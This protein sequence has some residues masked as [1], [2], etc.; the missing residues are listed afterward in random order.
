M[1][2]IF[3]SVIY[4]HH[5]LQILIYLFIYQMRCSAFGLSKVCSC[6]TSLK[7][8]AVYESCLAIRAC[9]SW[10]DTDEYNNIGQ[11]LEPPDIRVNFWGLDVTLI[12]GFDYGSIVTVEEIYKIII[13]QRFNCERT[14]PI[15]DRFTYVYITNIFG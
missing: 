1:E 11:I 15:L 7:R 13:K 3:I 4:A 14:K 6:I 8:F 10:T 2:S 5:I 12:S 9:S